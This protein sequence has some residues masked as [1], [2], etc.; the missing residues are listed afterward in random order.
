EAGAS[1]VRESTVREL[2]EGAQVLRTDTVRRESAHAP[3]IK[4]ARRRTRRVENFEFDPNSVSVEDLMRLGFS[5]KQALSID[6]YRAKG[7][8]FRRKSDFA[9]SYVVADS[10]YRRLEPYIR[11]PKVDI[12]TADSAGFDA[13]PGIGPYFAAKMEEYRVRLGGYSF[14][15]QLLDIYNFG[16]ERFDG[17]KDLIECSEPPAYELWTLPADELRKHPYIRSRQAADAIVL[18]R[19][20]TPAGSLSVE[21]LAAAGILPE[22]D[23]ARLARCRIAAPNVSGDD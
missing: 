21:G 1:S 7:G 14:P 3:L 9:K 2:P 16:E 6:N 20:N 4:E 15:E 5:E 23:A 17:L 8:R 10:V 11:I 12:N 22:E 13:L 18:Y 19:E